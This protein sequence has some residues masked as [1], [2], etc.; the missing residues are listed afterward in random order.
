MATKISVKEMT[1]TISENIN[2][3]SDK[4][5]EAFD[6]LPVEEKYKKIKKL[7]SNKNFY[8][9]KKTGTPVARKQF[10][11]TAKLQEMFEKKG[12]STEQLDEIIAFCEGYKETLVQKQIENLNKQIEILQRQRDGFTAIL[13]K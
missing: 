11:F 10:S 13:S 4:T 2:L 6:K 8:D 7:I 5:R 3:V 9:K 1:T 12:V